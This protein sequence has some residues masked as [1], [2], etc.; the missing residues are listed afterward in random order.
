MSGR[1]YMAKKKAPKR[2]ATPEAAAVAL[3]CMVGCL[4]CPHP[5]KGLAESLYLS[6]SRPRELD[7]L[8]KLDDGSFRRHA[9]ITELD[10][11]LA[12]K[13][14]AFYARVMDKSFE[15]AENGDISAEAWLKA[16]IVVAKHRDVLEGRVTA[17][18]GSDHPTQIF[19]ANYPAP[20]GQL[21]APAGE[22]IDGIAEVVEPRAALPVRKAIPEKEPAE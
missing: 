8:L 20:R 5:Q 3:E 18:A 21:A 10:V 7:L 6:G 12:K 4:V 16:G 11:R 15:A 2:A 9:Q 14:D 1:V 19:I 17:A 13:T 22:V